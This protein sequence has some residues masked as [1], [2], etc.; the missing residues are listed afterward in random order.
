MR[1]DDVERDLIDEINSKR[2]WFSDTLL[3]CYCF[4]NVKEEIQS[5]EVQILQYRRPSSKETTKG[6]IRL[7][8]N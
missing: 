7:N 4:V 6:G 3:F 1:S 5:K 2:G 8:T